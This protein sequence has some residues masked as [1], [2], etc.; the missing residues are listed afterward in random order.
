MAFARPNFRDRPTL[1]PH[2]SRKQRVFQSI[3]RPSASESHPT[4]L[5][6]PVSPQTSVPASFSSNASTQPDDEDDFVRSTRAWHIATALLSFSPHTFPRKKLNEAAVNAFLARK[7]RE[8][9][10]GGVL[11]AIQW[12]NR[13]ESQKTNAIE[14][15]T[16]N[17][18]EWFQWQSRRHFL[19]WS[20][21]NVVRAKVPL[22]EV[23]NRL[24]TIHA[25]YTEL[26]QH[27]VLH[28]LRSDEVEI[29]ASTY[30]Q[31]LNSLISYQLEKGDWSNNVYQVFLHLCGVVL[32][33]EDGEEDERADVEDSMRVDDED[34]FDPDRSAFPSIDET[35]EAVIDISASQETISTMPDEDGDI[36]LSRP[37]TAPASVASDVDDKPYARALYPGKIQR[38]AKKKLLRIWATLQ[39]LG[40]GGSGRRGE[41][42]FA[43]AIHTLITKYVDKSY[44]GVWQHP[45]SAQEEIAIWVSEG[46]SKLVRDVLNTN[47]RRDI[48]VGRTV[49]ARRI[50][51]PRASFRASTGRFSLGQMMD[52]GE[53][54]DDDVVKPEDIETWKKIAFTRLGRLRVSELFDIVVEWPDSKGGIQDLNDYISTPTTRL[55]LITTFNQT[56]NSRLLH[57]GASTADILKVYISLIEAFAMLDPKGV[58]LDRVS[59]GIRR[60]LKDRDDTLRIIVRGVFGPGSEG[61]SREEYSIDL[62]QSL[63]TQAA[64]VAQIID[65][66]DYD[67]MSWVPDPVDAGNDFKRSK[68]SDVVGSLLDLYENKESV[69]K[70]IQTYLAA[71]LLEKDDDMDMDHEVRKSSFKFNVLLTFSDPYPRTPQEPPLR[72]RRP[73]ILRRHDQR[74]LRLPSA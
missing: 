1:T 55:H 17:L 41:R 18:L 52:E 13:P 7:H 69:V 16:Q 15:E 70:E 46:V 39:L 33:V 72:R 14:R 63:A 31:E 35:V 4:P 71:R 27:Y 36:H 58:L 37:S 9:E 56:I 51:S 73:P 74:S 42:V 47:I 50:L 64:P 48:A 43:E 29:K 38:R 49:P 8:A 3:F 28:G 10:T 20:E 67:D 57:P 34:D 25:I 45:S 61:E 30:T 66:F 24:L 12:L 23:L 59:R 11:Q 65:D 22:E 53:G 60:Y 6:T 19:S 5:A 62:T 2:V 26:L 68:G 40:L 44:S 32:G 21:K 54:E